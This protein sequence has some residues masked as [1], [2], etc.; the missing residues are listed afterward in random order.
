M[1]LKRK[2]RHQTIH[3]MSAA[4][5]KGNQFMNFLPRGAPGGAGGQPGGFVGLGAP[6][7]SSPRDQ[8]A[9]LALP[10]G[11]AQ[12]PGDKPWPWRNASQVGTVR[13]SPQLRVHRGAVPCL[14]AAHKGAQSETGH[15]VPDG[16]THGDME[17]DTPL[18]KLYSFCVLRHFTKQRH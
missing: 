17:V 18:N 6:S 11:T 12:S 1:Q 10:A 3:V 8:R 2:P 16:Q 9:L 14:A 4:E 5:Y 15:T 7:P 13:C